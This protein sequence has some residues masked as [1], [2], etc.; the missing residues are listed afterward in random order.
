[1]AAW[2][3]IR[4]TSNP[5]FRELLL[6]SMPDHWFA[7]KGT[8]SNGRWTEIS[9]CQRQLFY[10][11]TYLVLSNETYREISSSKPLKICYFSFWYM[12][13]FSFNAVSW[14]PPK[15]AQG[16]KPFNIRN[17]IKILPWQRGYQLTN[18]WDNEATTTDTDLS[19]S[20]FLL[21]ITPTISVSLKKMSR[22]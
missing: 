5:L 22:T 8:Q 20:S 15:I 16:S 1:M 10:I 2:S 21:T 6:V 9:R 18:S 12:F 4:N 17:I 19:H 11:N 14:N 7:W 3:V 13:V